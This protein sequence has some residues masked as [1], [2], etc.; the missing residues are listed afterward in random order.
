MNRLGLGLHFEDQLFFD[1][2][3]S[4]FMNVQVLL[5][6]YLFAIRRPWGTSWRSGCSV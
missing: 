5:L 6:L 3:L 1:D 4:V 2:V